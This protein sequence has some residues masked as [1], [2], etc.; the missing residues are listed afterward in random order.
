MLRVNE[1]HVL[2]ERSQDRRGIPGNN[3]G[4]CLLQVFTGILNTGKLRFLLRLLFRKAAQ[5][6]SKFIH[7]IKL[8]RLFIQIIPIIGVQSGCRFFFRFQTVP[9]LQQ[10][11]ACKLRGFFRCSPVQRLGVLFTKQFQFA[12]SGR[13]ISLRTSVGRNSIAKVIKG[14]LLKIG[15]A[16]DLIFIQEPQ[17]LRSDLLLLPQGTLMIPF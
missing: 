5:R 15:Y 10:F 3:L 6:F 17:D 13:Y 9:L 14:K 1:L 12:F 4:L 7:F 2:F 11:L 8:R 16:R